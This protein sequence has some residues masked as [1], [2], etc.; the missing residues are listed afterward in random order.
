MMLGSSCAAPLSRSCVLCRR[1]A[2]S[3]PSWD[4]ISTSI[5]DA[6]HPPSDCASC[7][8]DDHASTASKVMCGSADAGQVCS[9][10]SFQNQTCM[11]KGLVI[12]AVC[13][14]TDSCTAASCTASARSTLLV[15]ELDIDKSVASS[16]LATRSRTEFSY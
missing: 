13:E 11:G 1:W 8:Q 3:L 16:T 5:G 4:L 7:F 14:T 10:A 12:Y 9:P 6:L 2:S 15:I